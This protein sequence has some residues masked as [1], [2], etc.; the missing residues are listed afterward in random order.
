VKGRVNRRGAERRRALIDAAIELWAQ[1][2]WRGTGVAAVAERAGVT[3]AGLLHHF[4]TKEN[5]LLEVIAEL[6]RHEIERHKAWGPPQGLDLVRR[7]PDMARNSRDRPELW[8][9]HLTLQAENLD[10][11]S[12]AFDYYIRRHSYLRHNW[13]KAIRVGQERGEIRP[14]ADPDL[15]A[16]EILAFL[17][18]MELHNNHGPEDISLV[19]VCE[20]FARRMIRDLAFDPDRADGAT[21]RDRRSGVAQLDTPS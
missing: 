5:F 10:P 1:T 8:K 4:G 16:T 13:A 21:V 14:D 6:D 18:G 15:V 3:D 20:D 12:P 17:Q 11:G 9:L 19:D 2:G 7:L